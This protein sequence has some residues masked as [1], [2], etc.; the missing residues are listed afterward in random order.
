LKIIFPYFRDGDGK[1]QATDRETTSGVVP[2]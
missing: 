1:T 2:D